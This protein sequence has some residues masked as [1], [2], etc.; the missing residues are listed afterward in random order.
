MRAPSPEGGY[1]LW[2]LI[3]QSSYDHLFSLSISFYRSFIMCLP[4]LRCAGAYSFVE[5]P[6][7]YQA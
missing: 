6:A 7:D 2:A 1:T 4:R 5:L 3:T